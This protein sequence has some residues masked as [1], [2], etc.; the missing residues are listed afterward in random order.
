MA[1][2]SKCIKIAQHLIT[3]SDVYLS[4]CARTQGKNAALKEVGAIVPE[5]F[6]GLGDTIAE[7]YQRLVADGVITPRPEPTPPSV[8]QDLAAAKKAGKARSTVLLKRRC[9]RRWYS[10]GWVTHAAECHQTR[11][12]TSSM[13]EDVG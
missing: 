8:P 13:T 2:S 9:A 10:G 4:R 3:A 6:E 11:A 1:S 12:R 7:V 5:S